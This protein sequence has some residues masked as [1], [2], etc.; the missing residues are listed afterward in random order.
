MGVLGIGVLRDGGSRD[1]GSQDEG[2]TRAKGGVT[3]RFLLALPAGR[4]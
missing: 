4:S 2:W 1:E 3:G